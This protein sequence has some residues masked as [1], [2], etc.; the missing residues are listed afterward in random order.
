[1]S[2]QFARHTHVALTSLEAVDGADVVQA[3]AGHIAAGGGIGTGH[4]PAGPERDG[5]HLE[6]GEGLRY[7]QDIMFHPGE[8]PILQT[9]HTVSWYIRTWVLD[10]ARDIPFWSGSLDMSHCIKG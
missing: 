10:Y 7:R 9:G 2:R 1:M 8:D 6:Q 5:M 4:H 3:T